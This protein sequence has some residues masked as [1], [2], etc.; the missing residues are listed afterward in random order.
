MGNEPYFLE[1][2]RHF[3]A[4]SGE[5]NSFY[6]PKNERTVSLNPEQIE[7]KKQEYQEIFPNREFTF[8]QR[9]GNAIFPVS[10]MSTR[11]AP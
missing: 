3:L 6:A 5:C 7:N 10:D 9:D 1:I 4:L 8:L 2:L 11:N